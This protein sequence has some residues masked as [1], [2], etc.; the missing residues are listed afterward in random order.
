MKAKGGMGKSS[1]YS[2][3][4]DRLEGAY[5]GAEHRNSEL[6]LRGKEYLRGGNTPKKGAYVKKGV[7]L[8]ARDCSATKSYVTKAREDGIQGKG[9]R[10]ERGTGKFSS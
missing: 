9:K 3:P 1:S 4:E 10:T 2:K 8:L 5:P 7:S 6:I